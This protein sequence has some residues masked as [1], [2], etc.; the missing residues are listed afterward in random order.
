MAAY[1]GGIQFERKYES[2]H[3]INVVHL[4][5]MSANEVASALHFVSYRSHSSGEISTSSLDTILI[6]IKESSRSS[7]RS[8]ASIR[9]SGS[10]SSRSSFVHLN[11]ANFPRLRRPLLCLDTTTW[12]RS[13]SIP[14]LQPL[15]ADPRAQSHLYRPSTFEV[16]VSRSRPKRTQMVEIARGE[17]SWSRLWKKA[18]SSVFNTFLNSRGS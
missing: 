17:C 5:R 15:T 18:A 4:H 1:Y 16:D 10:T 8:S 7:K 14:I 12:S 11:L 9:A 2:R 3:N 13:W 6:T